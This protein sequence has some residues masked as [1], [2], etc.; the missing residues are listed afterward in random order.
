M[1][2]VSNPGGGAQVYLTSVRRATDDRMHSEITLP[3]LH[4]ALSDVPN[5]VC[6]ITHEI[7]ATHNK[8]MAE[9]FLERVLSSVAASAIAVLGRERA[10]IL[11]THQL[12]AAEAWEEA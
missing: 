12:R 4:Y 7:V 11:L 5:G 2:E 10:C 3:D 9:E 1:C 6:A 8:A